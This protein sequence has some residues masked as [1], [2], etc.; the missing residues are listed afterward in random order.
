MQADD[1]DS[2]SIG[3]TLEEALILCQLK[4]CREPSLRSPCARD[5]LNTVLNEDQS[6]PRRTQT[7]PNSEEEVS[8]DNTKS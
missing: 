8:S 1:E 4:G 6:A 7:L 2:A 5:V 3:E